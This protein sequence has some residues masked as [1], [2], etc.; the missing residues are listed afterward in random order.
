LHFLKKLFQK[1]VDLFEECGL[2]PDVYPQ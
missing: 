1:R 2:D